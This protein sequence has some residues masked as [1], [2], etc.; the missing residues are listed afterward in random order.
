MVVLGG[1]GNI[2]GVITGALLVY[3]VIF[4]LLQQLPEYA[5]NLVNSIGLSGLAKSSGDY[6]GIA[7]FISR[8]KFLVFGLILVI[9]ML[10]RPQGLLPSRQR[11]QELKKG[12]KDDT[13]IEDVNAETT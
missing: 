4:V 5:T 3:Y 10:V 11:E 9:V 1:M 12:V 7:E 2:P 6:P 13:V 8:L